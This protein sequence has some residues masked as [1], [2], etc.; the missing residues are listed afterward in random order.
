MEKIKELH[1]LANQEKK[2]GIVSIINIILS[3][4]LR[5]TNMPKIIFS[6]NITSNYDS[7]NNI[8]SIDTKESIYNDKY[9]FN[10]AHECFNV[11]QNENGE[12]LSYEE[13]GINIMVNG[14]SEYRYY[15]DFE[16]ESSAFALAFT[17]FYITYIKEFNYEYLFEISSLA[18]NKYSFLKDREKQI[19]NKSY[20][21]RDKYSNI[22]IE[23]I[24][25]IKQTYDKY[26]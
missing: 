4:V 18:K 2:N 5:I 12:D 13:E 1:N 19:K 3:K 20:E 17:N 15:Y 9:I 10:I 8:I 22:F 25:V 7:L 6:D 23:C 26:L 11:F 16:V 14:C 24:N 21:Y